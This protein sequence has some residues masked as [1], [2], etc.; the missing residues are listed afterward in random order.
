MGMIIGIITTIKLSFLFARKN[1]HSILGYGLLMIILLL[2]LIFP[3][4]ILLST[5]WSGW[6]YISL[7]VLAI[8]GL[9][10]FIMLLYIFRVMGVMKTN[11]TSSGT[12]AK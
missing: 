9:L 3:V 11:K 1:V 4:L 10:S 8:Y 12:I 2:G 6:K 7:N 5:S